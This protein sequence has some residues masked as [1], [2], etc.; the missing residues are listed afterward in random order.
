MTSAGSCEKRKQMK[1]NSKNC[2]ALKLPNILLYRV[3]AFT[4]INIERLIPKHLNRFILS[5]GE[6]VL[7]VKIITLFG[8]SMHI[9]KSLCIYPGNAPLAN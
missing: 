9:H 1:L 3:E 4:L 2:S 6:D 7:F 5:R 8:F